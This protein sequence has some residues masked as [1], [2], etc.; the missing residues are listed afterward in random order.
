MI[1][2]TSATPATTA[3]GAGTPASPKP[4]AA[5]G[6]LGKDDFLRLLTTQLQHQDPMNP[7]DDMSFIG[8]MAQFSALE[9]TTNMA[10]SLERYG[11]SQQVA[12][13]VGLIGHEVDAEDSTGAT[14]TGTVDSVNIAAGSIV[15][16]VGSTKLSPGQILEIR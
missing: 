15:I 14:F 8:Q 16:N 1:N 5:G 3:T 12:Q 11:T 13:S 4:I 10:A 2:T 7:Q 9:Q 6:N